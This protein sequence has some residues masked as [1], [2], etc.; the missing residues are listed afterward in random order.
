MVQNIGAFAVSI[1]LVACRLRS[2][3]W[4]LAM[5]RSTHDYFS[6]KDSFSDPKGCLSSQLP[7]Q[8]T[9]L[10]NMEVARVLQENADS[11]KSQH[12]KYNL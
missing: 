5:C 10:A 7:S 1:S 11:I 12:D 9:A 6:I 4:P 2:M 8:A 3:V